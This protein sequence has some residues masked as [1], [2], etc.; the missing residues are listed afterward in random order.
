MARLPVVSSDGNAWGTVLNDFLQVSLNTDG[1]L[2]TSAL[3]GYAQASLAIYSVY[4]YGAKGDGTTDDTTAIQN[5]INAAQTAGGGIVYLPKGTYLVSS[6]LSITSNNV[7]LAGAGPGTLIQ[8]SASF[9]NSSKIIYMN[10]VDFCGVRDMQFAWANTTSSGNPTSDFINISQSRY[11]IYSNLQFYYG[12]AWCIN[13]IGSTGKSNLGT[14]IHNVH[15]LHCQNGIHIQSKQS[16]TWGGQHFLSNVNLELIDAGDALFIEDADDIVVN[17]LLAAVN[18]SGLGIPL[19]IKGAGASNFFSN[20]DIGDYPTQPG[21]QP[22]VLI[23]S[24][25]NGSPS[26]ITL[27]NGVIQQGNIGVSITAGKQIIIRGFKIGGNAGNG[28]SIS[29]SPSGIEIE[30]NIFTGNGVTAGTNYSI[31]NTGS[32]DVYIRDNI[33]QDNQGAGANQVTNA[34]H[35]SAGAI[36]ESG[37]AYTGTGWTSTNRVALTGGTITAGKVAPHALYDGELSIGSVAALTANTVYF[38]GV[39]IQEY[40]VLTG[41]KLR[42][43]TGGTGHFDVGVYA[44]NAGVPG[45][46]LINAA[47]TPTS[48][49]T[50][51][52]ATVTQNFTSSTWLAPGR[53][54]LAFWIDN[55]T[56]QV[57]RQ[58]AA[59]GF[60]GP[61][62]TLS[63]TGPC[64]SSGAGAANAS[65]KPIMAAL[66]SGNWS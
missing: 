60:S 28:I 5:T 9:P 53:Y 44:D 42:F 30:Q 3:S 8:P 14:V 1:T 21:T 37:N 34:I 16:P 6:E 26:N 55:A 12:G 39:T 7:V 27:S 45:A 31:G 51:V 47:A 19:H 23:E 49:T 2:L 35:S 56:D 66:I 48:L 41:M 38:V 20:I 33:F 63:S 50:S 65:V 17:N 64:P 62:R 25:A 22:T 29:G 59:T 54:W 11:G 43:G 15:A 32:G 52:S 4:A 57:L 46:L 13:S 58:S 40:A 10:Q 61:L 36:T 24:S 18:G